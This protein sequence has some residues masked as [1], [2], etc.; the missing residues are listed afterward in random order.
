[1]LRIL[2]LTEPGTNSYFSPHLSAGLVFSRKTLVMIG[3]GTRY[4]FQ[5]GSC[6]NRSR[7][8]ATQSATLIWSV[9]NSN[10]GC[11]GG[12]YGAEMPVKF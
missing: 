10:S 6:F 11:S 5:Q 2:F 12:S 7:I 3:T 4:S 9:R 1:M 8:A